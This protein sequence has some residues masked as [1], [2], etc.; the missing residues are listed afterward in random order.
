MDDC[1]SISAFRGKE[2]QQGT[3]AVGQIPTRADNRSTKRR[4]T[5]SL[6]APVSAVGDVFV[7]HDYTSHTGFR[8]GRSPEY[9][10]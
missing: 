7:G 8:K 5:M 2:L 1:S 4:A 10:H 9:I 6:S 3:S